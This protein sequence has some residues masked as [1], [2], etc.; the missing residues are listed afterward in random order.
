MKKS[1][2]TLLSLFISFCSVGS[3]E[4]TITDL[5]ESTTEVSE[6]SN[7]QTVNNI[8]RDIKYFIASTVSN[9]HEEMLKEWVLRAERLYFSRSTAI[10]DNLYPIYI[11]QLDRDNAQSAFELEKIFCQFLEDEHKKPFRWD[12]Y[13]A[14]RCADNEWSQEEYE[15]DGFFVQPNGDVAGSA[16]M[17]IRQRDGYS[18]FLSRTHDLPEHAS[19]MGFVTLHEMFH[20]FQNSHITSTDDY[21]EQRIINGRK[22][23]DNPDHDVP[24]WHEGVTV[25][26]SYIDYARET[27]DPSWFKDEMECTLFCDKDRYG[28]KS[29]LQVYRESGI[30]LNNIRYDENPEPIDSQIGYEVGAWFVAY[31]VEEHGE[32]KVINIYSLLDEYGFEEAFIMQFGKDYR[33]YLDEFD[34]FLD[35]PKENILNILESS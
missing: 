13:D 15:R 6:I 30:K 21:D 14:S 23:G 4:R 8:D 3:D 28:N 25:Y 17:S 31:L 18:L 33:S 34:K 10:V 19:S 11:V 20:I 35:L 29:R 32:E 12:G 2:L 5:D 7:N 22:S 1:F 16:I 27:N 9:E 24:W 26:F